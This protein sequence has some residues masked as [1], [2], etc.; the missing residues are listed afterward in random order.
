M[1]NFIDELLAEVLNEFKEDLKKQCVVMMGLPGAGKSTF[2]ETEAS[3]YI[4]G[5]QGFPV[6]NSDLQVKAA[7][8]RIAQRHFNFLE[9]AM[10]AAKTEEEKLRVLE[11]FRESTEY[12]SNQGNLIHVPVT[13]EWWEKNKR[14]GGDAMY[15]AFG[16][17]YYHV[18]FD[19]R[20]QAKVTN[21]KLFKEKITRAGKILVIDTTASKPNKIFKKLEK[22]RKEGFSNTIIYLEIDPDLCVARDEFRRNNP[23]EGRGVGEKVVRS[24]VNLMPRAFKAYK[25]EGE[26]DDGLVDRVLH[27]KWRGPANPSKG[28][29]ILQSD[30]KYAVKRKLRQ[31]KDG[32]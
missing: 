15:K 17:D 12:M 13:L 26:K 16:K 20:D 22:T 27:F 25:R 4:P 32:R 19:I 5:F 7:Q 21:E 31:M 6:V 10:S 28:E 18:Y 11:S 24:Y 23:E 14:G 8:Y 1:K 29:W 2:I 9:R 3:K 30:V